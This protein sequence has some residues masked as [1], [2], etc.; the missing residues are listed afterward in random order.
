MNIQK[1]MQQAQEMQGKL[2][3]MQESIGEQE[4]IGSAGGGVVTVSMT[5]KGYVKKVE[6]DS[7]SMKPEDKEIVEDLVAAAC[8]DARSK[9]DEKMAD[10][11]K[12]MM[13]EMGLPSNMQMPF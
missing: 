6:I 8:N 7:D 10:E 5:C 2:Q 4:V 11:T 12:K 13:E 9:A 3:E 1:M